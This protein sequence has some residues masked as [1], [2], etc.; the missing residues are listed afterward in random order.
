MGA[1]AGVEGVQLPFMRVVGPDLEDAP[2]S[3]RGDARR[4]MKA[5]A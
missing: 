4:G 5:S 3:L 2:A 1:K